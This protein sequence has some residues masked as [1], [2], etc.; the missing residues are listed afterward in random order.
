MSKP[1]LTVK[2]L[3]EITTDDQIEELVQKYS[4]GAEI[5]WERIIVLHTVPIVD[6]K[7][8]QVVDSYSLPLTK[9][10]L[11]MRGHLL[12][13]QNYIW[14]IITLDAIPQKLDQHIMSALE[15]MRGRKAQQAVSGSLGRG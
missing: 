1:G 6:Q 3:T 9:I 4:L 15:E 12:G 14:W 13:P 10:I 7:S 11:G 5:W 8:G 2:R